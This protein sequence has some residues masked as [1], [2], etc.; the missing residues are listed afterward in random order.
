MGMKVWASSSE[1]ASDIIQ[2]IGAKI[3]FNV[4]GRIH[5]YDT[6]PLEPPYENPFGYDINF[7]SF[8]K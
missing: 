8:E 7:T 2:A 4:A 6:E 5:I 3:G 1:E